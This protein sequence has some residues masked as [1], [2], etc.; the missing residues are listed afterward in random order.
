MYGK[1]FVF[2]KHDE[3][4]TGVEFRRLPTKLGMGSATLGGRNP[5]LVT[6]VVSP[7]AGRGAYACTGKLGAK[8]R[9]GFALAL[10]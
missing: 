1:R 4:G 2:L 5:G 6:S 7:A 10:R 9:P 8:R 3:N